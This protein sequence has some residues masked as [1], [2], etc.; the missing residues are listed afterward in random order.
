MW[1][2]FPFSREFQRSKI[3]NFGLLYEYV[4]NFQSFAHRVSKTAGRLGLFRCSS[5]AIHHIRY[6]CEEHLLH[7]WPTHSKS[8]PTR[9]GSLRMEFTPFGCDRGLNSSLV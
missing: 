4:M 8:S 5:S 1:A 9:K 7:L 3:S 6:T 2:M